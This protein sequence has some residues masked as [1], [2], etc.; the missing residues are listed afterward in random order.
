VTGPTPDPDDRIARTVR[1]HGLASLA[2]DVLSQTL[3]TVLAGGLLYLVASAAGALTASRWAA[4][5]VVTACLV[6]V[7]GFVLLQRVPGWRRSGRGGGCGCAVCR[8]VG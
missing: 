5:L 1:V 2:S 3:G 7:A 8:S 4:L 6:P